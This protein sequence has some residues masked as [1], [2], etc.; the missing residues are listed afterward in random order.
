MAHPEE[1]TEARKRRL[2]VLAYANGFTL[3]HFRSEHDKS[4]V[5][6]GRSGELNFAYD[7][8]RAGDIVMVNAQDATFLMYIRAI[9]S[10]RVTPALFV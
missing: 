10:G 4:R 3:W 1:D 7:I 2:S 5:T 9:A 8:I 6:D